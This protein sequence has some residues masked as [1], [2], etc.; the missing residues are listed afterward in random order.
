MTETNTT[1]ES[2]W[3]PVPSTLVWPLHKAGIREDTKY[4]PNVL[5]N[6]GD[7]APHFELWVDGKP[8]R[9][10]IRAKFVSS[11]N[12]GGYHWNQQE[13]VYCRLSDLPEDLRKQVHE[14]LSKKL[15][16][17]FD[18]KQKEKYGR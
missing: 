2:K 12:E 1:E 4:I 3:M 13:E 14:A 9:P 7:Q 8:A 18:A 6:P 10:F 11:S 16:P 5:I 15:V 17:E